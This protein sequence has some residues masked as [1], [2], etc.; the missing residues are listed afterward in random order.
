[1]KMPIFRMAAGVC[2]GG[3]MLLLAG[4]GDAPPPPQVSSTTYE[5]TTTTAPAAPDAMTPAPGGS[6]TTQTTHSVSTPAD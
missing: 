5:Q 4:C 1:M 2:T 3:A 6:V